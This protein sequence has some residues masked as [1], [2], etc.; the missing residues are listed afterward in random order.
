MSE[1]PEEGPRN[2]GYTN[3]E[4]GLSDIIVTA[5]IFTHDRHK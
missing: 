5:N 4:N 3:P 2:S 1:D